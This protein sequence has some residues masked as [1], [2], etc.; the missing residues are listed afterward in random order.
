MQPSGPC[1]ECGSS[2]IVEDSLYSQTQFVCEDCGA[3]VSEGLL[4]T[5][6]SEEKHL[7]EVKFS[8]LPT[9]K[10]PGRGHIQGLQRIRSLCRI[11]RFSSNIEESSEVL[12]KKAYYHPAF[13]ST[14]AEKKEALA[15]CCVLVACRQNDWP[16]TMG[17]ISYLL[18]ANGEVMHKV[19]TELVQ[20]L[21]LETPPT[22]LT[23]LIESHCNSFKL[24]PSSCPDL[25]SECTTRLA[26]RAS[27]LLELADETWLV[28]GRQPVPI[29]TAVTYMSWLSL[30]PIA[31]RLN[32]SL[33]N[34]C[35]IA[36]VPVPAPASKRLIELQDVL[37]KLGQGLPWL[38]GVKLDRKS[39][40]KYTEDILKHRGIL[41]RQAMRKYEEEWENEQ[42]CSSVLL[43][44]S[45]EDSQGPP[46]KKT[47]LDEPSERAASG[48]QVSS[49]TSGHKG[50]EVGLNSEKEK[51]QCPSL[52]LPP[53][54][55]NPHPRR[56]R[57]VVAELD[58]FGDEE[59]LDS[60]IDMYIRTPEEVQALCRAQAKLMKSS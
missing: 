35:K 59:I 28:T 9:E 57:E 6:L 34:F 42:K 19:Y 29:L 54:L 40:A 8:R 5:T 15:G 56:E 24:S 22:D 49:N 3:V 13:L 30:R 60:E 1:P 52:F 21:H 27:E 7:N 47:K 46:L 10:Q 39:V 38:R 4:T 50:K 18:Q 17:T 37:C 41:L 31:S 33:I 14:H 16:I 45:E 11:L 51:S 26:K 58:V 44:D 48:D 53:C 32:I 12:F 2:Q 23:Q 25:F 20:K 36:K 43:S 55:Q